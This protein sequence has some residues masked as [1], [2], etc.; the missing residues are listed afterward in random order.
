MRHAARGNRVLSA[1]MRERLLGLGT[2]AHAAVAGNIRCTDFSVRKN[3]KGSVVVVT[4]ASSG[5]GRATAL[6]FARRGA[7]VVLAARRED[8]LSEVAAECRAA[9]T[10]AIAVATDVSDWRAVQHLALRAVEHFGRIDTWI[11]N[12]GVTVL[13]RFDEVPLE[14]FRRVMDVNFFGTVHGC[15]AVLPIFHRKRSGVLINMSSMVGAVAQQYASAYVASKHAVRA[16]GMTLRQELALEGQRGVHVCTIMPATIDTP[17]F[18][19]AANY[20][21]RE[22]KAMPPVYR[23]ERVARACVR[24]AERPRREMFVGNVARQMWSQLVL[25][26][27]PTERQLALMTDRLHFY[28]DRHNAPTKGNLYTPMAEGAGV[29]G[30]WGGRRGEMQRRLAAI[31]ALAAVGWGLTSRWRSQPRQV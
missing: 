8:L 4:G 17:F 22:A 16:L 14:D 23:V 25:A 10:D 29:D 31:A 24:L 2:R 6:Q 19:H 21:G 1:R 20:L 26:P 11:N 12:H 27:A 5:I 15:R 28:Q 3:I 9:G 18:Q 7:S 13:G 30:G